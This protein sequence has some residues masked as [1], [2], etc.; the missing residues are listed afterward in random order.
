MVCYQRPLTTTQKY[1][2][3]KAPFYW[4]FFNI[5]LD[6]KGLL[7]CYDYNFT[8]ENLPKNIEIIIDNDPKDYEANG[9]L[10]KLINFFLIP[11]LNRLP[12]K[13][14]LSSSKKAIAVYKHAT[15]HK[16]L[17]IIYS[18]DNKLNF[19]KGILDGFFTYF[20]QKT[21]NAKA[22]R[23]RLK[24]VKKELKKAIHS[25]NKR[26]LR[27]LNLACGSN[28]A[29]IEVVGEHKDN[30]D[31]EVFA[32]DK[33]ISAIEDAQKL[34]FSF[35]IAH[36]L[37]THQS[38]ISEF[39]DKSKNIKFDI[40]EVV[41]FLD[42]V[43]DNKAIL[44]FNQIYSVLTDNGI[45]ITGNIKDNSERKFVTEVVGWPKLIFRNETDLINLL[46]N[47]KFKSSKIKI[48]YE[49]QNIHGVIICRK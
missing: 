4:A 48:I 42:Y 40:V 34:A 21:N 14:F 9:V 23:N 45:F 28:R 12:S 18:F 31:F 32:V 13:L 37:K 20:W 33:S 38:T 49:P 6:Y 36:L 44:L 7:Y 2:C 16:A 29:V 47:S 11:I 46:M 22:L 5:N 35:D 19:E 41:G 17:E 43:E 24:L 15:T 25:F 26:D 8:M 30:F 10:R 1:F 3:H 39:L 27:I